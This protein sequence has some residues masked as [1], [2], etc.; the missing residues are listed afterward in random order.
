MYTQALH[1]TLFFN[2]YTVYPWN[3]LSEWMLERLFSRLAVQCV[4]LSWVSE[5]ISWTHA[6]PSLITQHLYLV[7]FWPP[8]G[9]E[10]KYTWLVGQ[11]DSCPS[12]LRVSILY[13]SAW[14]FKWVLWLCV[15]TSAGLLRSPVPLAYGG[16]AA[17]LQVRL[18]AGRKA[19]HEVHFLLVRE[20]LWSSAGS[21]LFGE[22]NVPASIT[23]W[24]PGG[25]VVLQ[26][27]LDEDTLS[28]C[29]VGFLYRKQEATL[30]LLAVH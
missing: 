19:L 21:A 15:R 6:Q 26:N 10:V 29:T 25:V 9:S 7:W 23:C 14:W 1:S 24:H 28:I 16:E 11:D 20:S 5:F 30:Y 13:R 2:L 18:L 3:S 27:H 4:P 8:P 12:I 17:V 22:A